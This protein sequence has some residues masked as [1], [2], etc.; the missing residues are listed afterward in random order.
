[1]YSLYRRRVFA[2]L[3]Q[4]WFTAWIM[5]DDVAASAKADELE[6]QGKFDLAASVRRELFWEALPTGPFRG[7]LMKSRE[8]RYGDCW[9]VAPNR[10]KKLV[11]KTT[12]PTRHR[13][14]CFYLWQRAIKDRALYAVRALAL[15]ADRGKE[16]YIRVK[17]WGLKDIPCPICYFPT[18]SR[19]FLQTS[20]CGEKMC[21]ECF[22]HYCWKC[23]KHD[24]NGLF[25]PSSVC[26]ACGDCGPHYRPGHTERAGDDIVGVDRNGKEVLVTYGDR[27]QV[28]GDPEWFELGEDHHY[29]ARH[30]I[31]LLGEDGQEGPRGISYNG[32][33]YGLLG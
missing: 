5:G 29:S 10:Q 25:G 21:E 3:I 16:E 33:W 24:V 8:D 7:E 14:L 18:G 13:D 27:W 26:G 12:P 22:P 11:V 2:E 15:L 20:D 30:T 31:I 6:K 4:A 19:R 1:M 23:K 17:T 9:V 28:V 32:A